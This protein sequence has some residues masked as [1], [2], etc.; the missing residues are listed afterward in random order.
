MIEKIS[1]LASIILM[2]Y[3]LS[4]L[5]NR[6][7]SICEKA[8]KY[9]EILKREAMALKELRKTNIYIS[10]FVAFVYITLLFFSEISPY[11]LLI[12]VVKFLFSLYFSDRFQICVSEG[13]QISKTLYWKL[14]LDS[15][16]NFLGAIFIGFI[17]VL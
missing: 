1:L 14:K 5:F 11:F 6:Y 4:L 17:L 7:I 12:I 2:G 9:R 15:L 16:V 13:I 3:N 10:T 8:L